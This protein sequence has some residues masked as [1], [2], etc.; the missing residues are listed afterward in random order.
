MTPFLQQ[1]ASVFYQHYQNRIN[2]LVFVF[3]NRRAGIFFQKYLAIEAKQPVFSPTI[4][5]INELFGKLSELHTADHTSLLFRLYEIFL[6]ISHSQESFDD[7]YYWGEMLLNDFDDVDK[8][9]ADA[10]KLFTNV[11]DLKQ[12]DADFASLEEE[13]LAVIRRFWT[14]FIPSNESI[15]KE[16]FE[17]T[18]KVLYEIYDTLRTRLRKDGLAY[19]GMIFREVAEKMLNNQLTEIPYRKIVFVGLNALTMAEKVL[20]KGLRNMGIADFYWDYQSPMLTDPD[21][22]ASFFAVENLKEFPSAYELAAFP[23]HQRPEVE[24]ISVPSSVGQTKYTYTLLEQLIQSGDIPQPEYAMNTAVV[25]PDENLLLPMLY[26][27]PSDINPINVTMGYSL[28]NTPIAGLM[29]YIFELQRTVRTEGNDVLFYHHFVVAILNHRYITTYDSAESTRLIEEIRSNNK[30]YISQSELQCNELMRLIF[31]KVS[32]IAD[33]SGY[34]TSLLAFLQGGPD[35][36]TTPDEEENQQSSVRLTEIENEFIY[37]YYLT[38]NRLAD[39]MSTYSVAFSLSTYFRLLRQLTESISIPFRGEPLSGLQVMGVLETRALDFDNQIILSMNEGVFPMKKAANSFIPFSL[40]K[41]FG[42]ST[43]EHQDAIYAYHFYRMISRAKKVFLIYDSRSGGL[44]TGEVSRYVYQLKYHYCIPVKERTVTYDIAV[45]TPSSI[46]IPKTESVRKKLE[47]FLQGGSRALSASAINTYLNCPLMFYF[48]T[49]EGM[50]EEE[51]VTETMQA[52]TFGTIFH[53]MMADIY[54]RLEGKMVTA[55]L[56]RGVIKD[57]DGLHRLMQKYFAEEYLKNG[58]EAQPLTGFNYLIGEVLVKYVCEVLQ[59]D[60]QFT[61]FIYLHSELP[62][63][64]EIPISKDRIVRL[65]GFIDRVDERDNQV[66]IIDYKTG[67]G[68]TEFSSWDQLFSQTEKKR[69]K[70]VMQVLFY[71]MLYHQ[72]N[73]PKA[74][75]PHLF[76]LRNMFKDNNETSVIFKSKLPMDIINDGVM[77]DF[78]PYEQAF[79][80]Q[81]ITCL[82][83]IFDYETPFKQTE[84]VRNCQYCPFS[85]ICK[86]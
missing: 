34:L 22:K 47:T 71:S 58:N 82:D 65:K 60:I 43:T 54:L 55:D 57:K 1:V 14:H 40:R 41:A 69:P 59:K 80:H 74:I 39:V 27:I 37:H 16:N 38:V 31:Q 2:E 52:N 3:P 8:Y 78:L 11:T 77:T 25:L 49:I 10:E 75:A 7:F 64:V 73:H 4:L 18:W 9:L 45:E 85:I 6:E 19:E 76:Y 68:I 67:S 35:E 17:K 12:I 79:R 13:Q 24:V 23:K 46:T 36:P 63:K 33:V 42:L 48:Q 32:S 51:E 53:R 26:S 21:N 86:R 62:V 61:P 30:V 44:Q 5:T 84:Q 15:R 83:E 70:A 56:L 81:L 28:K 50:D 66:R 20:M 29:H 72:E